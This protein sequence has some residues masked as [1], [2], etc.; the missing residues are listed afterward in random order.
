MEEKIISQ[1]F[2]KKNNE[3]LN[4]VKYTLQNKYC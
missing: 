1:K 2:E 3:I 4:I